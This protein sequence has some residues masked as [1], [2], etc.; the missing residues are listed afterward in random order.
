MISISRIST[1]AFERMS[2]ANTNQTTFMAT[3]RGL[4]RLDVVYAKPITFRPVDTRLRYLREKPRTK[5]AASS[6]P[7]FG[8]LL[9]L[10]YAQVL[11]HQHRIL[12]NPLAQLGGGLLAECPVAVGLF[13]T[14]PFKRPADTAGVLALC[15]V[16]GQLLLQPLAGFASSL[17]GLLQS[18]ARDEQ[19]LLVGGCYQGVVDA[20]V[21]PY[22][23][24][25]FGFRNLKRDAQGDLVGACDH[26]AV[27]TDSVGEVSLGVIRDNII[28]FLPSNGG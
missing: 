18:G 23:R 15:L 17:V 6:L 24:D 12:G 25:G 19:S 21:Y 13:S 20:K 5:F 11:K 4:E 8:C 28:K 9:D 1:G 22:R 3:L 26:D 27:I 7:V 2:E 10:F 14:Q 16:I